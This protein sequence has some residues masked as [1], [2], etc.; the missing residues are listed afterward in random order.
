MLILI[1]KIINK[2]YELFK[3][4]SYIKDCFSTYI[5]RN[6]IKIVTIKFLFIIILTISVYYNFTVYNIN[7][8]IVSSNVALLNV[9]PGIMSDIFMMK[10]IPLLSLIYPSLHISFSLI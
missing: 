1:N 5:E 8:R 9:S 6:E 4:V 2:I 7:K 3:D 10:I